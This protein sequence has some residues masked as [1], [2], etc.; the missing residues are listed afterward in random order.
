MPDAFDGVGVGLQQNQSHGNRY[1]TVIKAL[2]RA[3]Q[4]G[5]RLDLPELAAWDGSQKLLFTIDKVGGVESSKLKAMAMG[6]GVCWAG[7]YAVTAENASVVIDV[8]HGGITF[9]AANPVLCSVFGGFYVDA[10]RRAG[11]SAEKASNA[12]LQ[13][14]FVA[15]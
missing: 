7:F 9:G 4:L 3:F 2:V 13:A 5:L 8:V 1:L 11:S 6:D 10:I 12:L 14:I 15:L